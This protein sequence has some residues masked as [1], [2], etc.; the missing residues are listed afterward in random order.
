MDTAA[1]LTRA[2]NGDSSAFEELVSAYQRLVW[3]IVRSF[4]MSTAD[5]EDV[6]QGVW[7]A[8]VQHLG[9]IR[10][11]DRLAAWIATTCRRECIAV[12]KRSSR[13][14]RFDLEALDRVIAPTA[15]NDA[16]LVRDERSRAVAEAMADLDDRCR[17][18]ITLL[19]TDPPIGYADIAVLMDMPVGAIGPTR[20]RCL[21]KMRRHRAIRRIQPD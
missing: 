10:E 3:A 7:L 19:G 13:T 9:S 6:V 17:Q 4:G 18:L 11:P 14:Q 20:Q 21:D 5:G 16:A 1:L 2:A 8:F 12:Q 15:P